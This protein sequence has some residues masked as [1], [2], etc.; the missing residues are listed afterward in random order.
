VYTV[1]TYSIIRW[2]QFVLDFGSTCFEVVL[3]SVASSLFPKFRLLLHFVLRPFLYRLEFS[4]N[5]RGQWDVIGLLP[6]K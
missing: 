5:A 3:L 2:Q 4:R 1:R 6:P